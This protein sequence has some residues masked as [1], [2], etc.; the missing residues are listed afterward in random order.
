MNTLEMAS[1]GHPVSGL[2]LRLAEHLWRMAVVVLALMP[3]GMAIAHRSSPVF[4]VLSA[5]CALGATA[6][7]AKLRPVLREALAVLASPLGMAVLAFL[8]W[9]LV[10]IGWSEF[11]S[12]SLR[13]FGEFLL[14]LTAAFALALTLA[15]RMTRLGF[16]LLTG[17]FILACFMMVFELRSGLVLRHSLGMRS[18]SFIFNRPVLTLLVLV[19]PLAAWFVGGVRHGWAFSIGLV[20]LLSGTALLSDSGAA[21]LGLIMA[22]LACAMAWFA[23]RWAWRLAGVAFAVAMIVA[24]AIGPISSNLI[25]PSLHDAIAGGHSRERVEVWNSFGAAVREQPLLGAGFGVSPRMGETSVARKVPEGEQ[26][27]L[28]IGHPHNVALQIWV[29]LGVVGVALALAVIFLLLRAVTRQSDLAGA[30]SLTLIGAAATV[31]LVGHGAW[32]G[33]WAASLGA[34]IL[35]MIAANKPQPETG[36]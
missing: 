4:L 20:L 36:P 6:L 29:E 32:Q 1:T 8:G 5:L 10:S 7:E 15:R 24:P 30:F 28:A 2:R 17:A 25:S 26:K 33:W 11:R 23:P 13:A 27:M 12:T 22:G 9:C 34:A 35:W 18:D 19:P 31:A 21:V 3:V 14:P 16:W